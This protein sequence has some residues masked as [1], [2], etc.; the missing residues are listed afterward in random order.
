[1]PRAEEGQG[2]LVRGVPLLQSCGELEADGGVEVLHAGAQIGQ[3]GVQPGMQGHC[4]TAGLPT[5]N[6]PSQ[7]Q[8]PQ[9]ISIRTAPGRI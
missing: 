7:L 1:M 2:R 5:L 9:C 6:C 8:A 3:P 4:L